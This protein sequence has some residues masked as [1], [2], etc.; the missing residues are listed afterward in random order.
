MPFLFLEILAVDLK[1]NEAITIID[2]IY[3]PVANNIMSLKRGLPPIFLSFVPALLGV[4]IVYTL[5]RCT[6]H[7]ICMNYSTHFH[8]NKFIAD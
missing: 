2:V 4:L 1:D 7:H 6:V 5:Q 8:K 3:T